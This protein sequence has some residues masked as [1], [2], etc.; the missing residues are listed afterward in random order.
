MPNHINDTKAIK[1]CFNWT[2]AH[3]IAIHK[4]K[5]AKSQELNYQLKT[6]QLNQFFRHIKTPNWLVLATLGI[7]WFEKQKTFSVFT[8]FSILRNAYRKKLK[9]KQQSNSILTIFIQ[10]FK[11]RNNLK[12]NKH[13]HTHTH[14]KRNSNF[15][16]QQYLAEVRDESPA[17]MW[18]ALEI[19]QRSGH[20]SLHEARRWRRSS[21]VLSANIQ[22]WTA[23]W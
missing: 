19:S 10:M 21:R 11:T 4:S 14:T 18:P 20:E 16:M 8:W 13:T 23:R 3:A 22:T 7:L 2:R 12:T 17:E 1:S 6:K 9:K 15:T 5:H